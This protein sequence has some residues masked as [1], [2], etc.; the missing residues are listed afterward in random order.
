MLSWTAKLKQA[1]AEQARRDADP[2]CDKVAAAV[3]GMHEVSTH[4]LLDLIGLPPTTH[5]G[6]RISPVMRSLGFVAIKSRRF[7]PGGWKDSVTRGWAKPVRKPGSN[8]DDK[9][10]NLHLKTDR[11]DEQ[12]DM[13]HGQ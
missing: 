6:R 5:N 13:C 7:M 4:A 11:T 12:K 3:R 2:L 8:Q 10:G 9:V 1:C